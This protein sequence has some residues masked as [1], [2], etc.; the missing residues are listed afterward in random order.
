MNL[1][2]AIF[3][4][5]MSGSV[6]ILHDIN[7]TAVAQERSQSSSSHIIQIDD[8]DNFPTLIPG[9]AVDVIIN[10]FTTNPPR[11]GELV[12]FARHGNPIGPWAGPTFLQIARVI[13]LPGDLV[14]FR[15]SAMSV[16]GHEYR[17][18][19]GQ[20]HSV[21]W[22]AHPG[23]PVRRDEGVLCE[24][25]NVDGVSYT[26]FWGAVA[27]NVRRSIRL[28][29]RVP[30]HQFLV[31]SDNRLTQVSHA[32]VG[33]A[34]RVTTYDDQMRRQESLLQALLIRAPSIRHRPASIVTNSTN[35]T[36]RGIN[37]QPFD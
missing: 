32:L 2:L 12:V 29:V 17:C 15:G 28:N 26:V 13:G 9:D 20:W 30:E 31:L 27:R 7:A 14:E 16:N 11:R 3:I 19:N 1:I 4:Y 23:G 24:E 10:H 36:R 25:R 22:R 18:E 37:V 33:P 6:F 5:V 34:G 35:N 21:P 8:I